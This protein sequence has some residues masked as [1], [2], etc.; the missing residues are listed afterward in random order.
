MFKVLSN[1]GENGEECSDDDD[2]TTN[3][4]KSSSESSIDPNARVTKSINLLIKGNS[5]VINFFEFFYQN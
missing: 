3:K 1:Q 2:D 4:S 5:Q